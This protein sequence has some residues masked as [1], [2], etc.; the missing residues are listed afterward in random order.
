MSI[1]AAL[2]TLHELLWVYHKFYGLWS[3]DLA[4]PSGNYDFMRKNK[5]LKSICVVSI[6]VQYADQVGQVR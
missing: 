3:A 4:S 5:C 6:L 2:A 1:S